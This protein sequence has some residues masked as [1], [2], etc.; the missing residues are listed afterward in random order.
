MIEVI[1]KEEKQEAKG[2]EAVFR[3]PRNIR[4]IGLV[5]EN[6]RIYMEDYV[7]TFLNRLAGMQ[8]AKEKNGGCVAVLTGD[9]KWAEGTA[10]L[11]IRG[12]LMAEDMEAAADHIDFTDEI[13]TAIHEEQE[14]YFPDQEIVGWFFAQP[15]LS[16][17]AT[18]I[19]TRIHLKYFGGEKVMMLM[20]PVEKE[21]A[22]FCYENGLMIR[23]SGYYIYYEKN[24]LMQTYMIDKNQEIRPELTE[25]VEDK[26]VKDFRKIILGKKKEE[27]EETEEK[28]SVF[29]YAA[30]ACLVIAV[31]AVGANFYRNYQDMQ[32]INQKAKEAASIIKEVEDISATPSP[33]AVE[34][35]ERQELPAE[36]PSPEPTA[37]ITKAPKERISEETSAKE[38]AKELLEEQEP[39]ENVISPDSDVYQEESD[40]RK[41]MRRE[42]EEQA[43]ISQGAAVKQEN[44]SGQE[45]IQEETDANSSERQTN[46]EETTDEEQ[47]VSGTEVHESYVI[48]PGDTLYQISMDK[49]GNMEAIQEICRLN[50]LSE[51]EIIYPGQV[52]VLP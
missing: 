22:F 1:Y 14:K 19:F 34:K 45:N 26:A 5:N 46:G 32:V 3:I 27:P 40:V 35:A 41:A 43:E 21:D 51:Q 50:N 48:R 38:T 6:Y 30:T 8:G 13:W 29:S 7:F 23:Q 9:T 42:A 33:S 52:I 49:Y 44:S 18:E 2:N 16:I 15:Q 20:D 36:T 39:Q 47:S 4:Q 24:P 37:A 11:F 31:L 12:A 17:E 10:Y 28:T 25:E